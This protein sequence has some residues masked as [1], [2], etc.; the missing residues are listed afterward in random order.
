MCTKRSPRM[1][2]SSIQLNAHLIFSTKTC[3]PVLNLQIRAGVHEC[4]TAL[5]HEA[6]SPLA[7]AGGT[8]DHVHMLIEMP[9]LLAPVDVVE[10]VKKESEAFVRKLG[11]EFEAFSWQR[12][13]GMFSVGPMQKAGVERYVQ[14]QEEHHKKR[15][16][17]DEFRGLLEWYDI[18]YDE[19]TMWD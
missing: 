10:H 19:Q 15:S 16:F 7:V 17:Q 9:N 14:S 11:P 8:A 13:Y 12:G 6:G 18:E 5:A 3:E 4:L 1:P 2:H